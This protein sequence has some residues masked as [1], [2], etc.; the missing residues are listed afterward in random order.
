MQLAAGIDPDKETLERHLAKQVGPDRF[1]LDGK[2]M[3]GA[4]LEAAMK[5]EYAREHQ[6]DEVY[7][8]GC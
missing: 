5:T 7:A 4:E 8:E 2:E 3:S 1:L 6:F